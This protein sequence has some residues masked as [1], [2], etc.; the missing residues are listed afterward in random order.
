MCAMLSVNL[1]AVAHLRNRRNI[2]WPDVVDYG[3][4]TLSAGAKGLTIHPRPDERHIRHEDVGKLKILFEDEAFRGCEYNIEG[5]PDQ[6]FMDLIRTHKPH[7]VTF[8][9]DSP[10]QST[11]DHGWDFT[12]HHSLLQD[13]VKEAQN[14]GIRTA[15]FLD[16]LP[17]SCDAAAKTGAERIEI[18]TG[19]FGAITPPQKAVTQ[20]EAIITTQRAA[21]QNGLGVNAGHDLTLE[22]MP[23]LAIKGAVFD[24]VS[25]G[26]AFWSDAW[27]WGI[28]ATVQHYIQASQQLV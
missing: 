1:N 22:N 26:H 17:S 16:P 5:Y 21:M 9:P 28:E 23:F 13:V 7:Q 8:V 20:A 25:I 6:R 24:E 11:S 27:I 18:Y 19:L 10:E 14:L 15:L 2:G 12:Q 4:K 3:R